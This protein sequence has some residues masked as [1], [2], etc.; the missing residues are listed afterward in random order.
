[1]SP[2]TDQRSASFPEQ[3]CLQNRQPKFKSASKSS[4]THRENHCL[5]EANKTG[6]Q[7]TTRLQVLYN[8]RHTYTESKHIEPEKGQ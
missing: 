5:D 8:Q 6:N 1:M 7:Y 4:Y 3:K 2:S